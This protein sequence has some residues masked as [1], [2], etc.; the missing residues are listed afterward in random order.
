MSLISPFLSYPLSSTSSSGLKERSF[1]VR[2]TILKPILS[3]IAQ[4]QGGNSAPIIRMSEA[5]KR[6]SI[7]KHSLFKE[8]I[9]NPVLTQSLFQYLAAILGQ[10]HSDCDIAGSSLERLPAS[11]GGGIFTQYCQRME[12]KQIPS[13][14]VRL[15]IQLQKMSEKLATLPEKMG[16]AKRVHD[17]KI[18]QLV[19][20]H[21]EGRKEGDSLQKK[22]WSAENEKT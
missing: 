8:K 22:V 2:K 13:S 19:Q 5:D 1:S 20:R 14:V 17:A 10:I 16:E 3:L 9:D 11:I 18:A 21:E 12:G 15:L 4:V 6:Q 7:T